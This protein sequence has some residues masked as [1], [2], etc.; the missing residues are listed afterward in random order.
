MPLSIYLPVEKPNQVLFGLEPII[1]VP[2]ELIGGLDLLEPHVIVLVDD[3]D[4][5]EGDMPVQ[6][7]VRVLA[8]LAVILAETG[9]PE[10][11]AQV[12]ARLAVSLGARLALRKLLHRE[13]GG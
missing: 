4:G 3:C 10:F 9:A 7:A 5:L 13:R 1:D 11:F 2:D 12:L 8:H 6:S